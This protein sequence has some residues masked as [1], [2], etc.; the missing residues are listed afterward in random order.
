MAPAESTTRVAALQ[1]CATPDVAG[2]L[3]TVQRLARQAR[4]RGA[5]VIMLPEAFAFLGPE[6]D[7]QAVLEPL[8]D[9]A[10]AGADFTPGPILEFCQTLARELD[11]HL[12]LGGFHETAPE[13]GKSFNTCVHL[14][15][16]GRLAARYRK[17]H[18]FD[19]SLDDG[20]ELR[21]SKRTMPGSE[22]VVSEL[23][24]GA[25]GLT[26]CYDLRFPYLYQRLADLGAVALTVPSAFTRPTGAAHW[27][28]LL[29][30]RAIET[31][32]YVIAPAQHGQNWEKRASYGHSLIIDPWGEVVDELDDGDGMVMADID[33]ARVA[34]VRRQ[35][36]SLTHRVSVR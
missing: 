13:P 22:A 18:L 32:C 35:L 4:E 3:A 5:E 15:P 24:F 30:A 12:I 29:R 10:A 2:N 7:K 36:P 1:L 16:A 9:P 20:T 21:E 26:V 8:P 31:Q 34:A 17:I 11:A 19:V 33:P 28:V 6:R 27:H 23:P 25:L 14:D